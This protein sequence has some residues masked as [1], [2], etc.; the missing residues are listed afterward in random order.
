MISEVQDEAHFHSYDQFRT[1][2]CD[3]LGIE[4][5]KFRLSMTERRKL[6]AS[7]YRAVKHYFS[8]EAYQ[9]RV[10]QQAVYHLDRSS[11]KKLVRPSLEG[12]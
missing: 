11:A 8:E 1:I 6:I 12:I 2:Y 4:S 5:T 3:S 10:V 7:G 9:K